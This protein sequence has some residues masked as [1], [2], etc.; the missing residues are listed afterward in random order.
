MFLSF[1]AADDQLSILQHSLSPSE[2]W[3]SGKGAGPQILT[4]P[5]SEALASSPGK[6][7]FQLTQF[8]VRV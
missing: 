4:V 8:T 2:S 7:G 5:S 1:T 3:T 6:M